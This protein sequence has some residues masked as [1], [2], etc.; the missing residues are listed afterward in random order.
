MSGC[1]RQIAQT[2]LKNVPPD[3]IIPALDGS[4]TTFFCLSQRVVASTTSYERT[5][6]AWLR[7]AYY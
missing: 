7:R 6:N 2:D 4:S 3:P 5:A 1:L